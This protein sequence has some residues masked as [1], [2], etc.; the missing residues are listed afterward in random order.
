MSRTFT[1]SMA[2]EASSSSASID[3]NSNPTATAQ[4]ILE[5]WKPSAFSLRTG[6]FYLP[7]C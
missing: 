3:V 1:R 2:T 7:V 4:G 6:S 5:S